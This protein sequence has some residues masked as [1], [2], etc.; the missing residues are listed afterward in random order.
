MKKLFVVLITIATLG[1]VGSMDY[2]DTNRDYQ[3]YCDNVNAGVWPAY[4]GKC[5]A[6]LP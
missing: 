1:I 3:L 6:K 2:D 5:D 4:K